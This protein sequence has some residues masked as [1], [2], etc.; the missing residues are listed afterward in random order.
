[1]HPPHTCDLLSL[2]DGNYHNQRPPAAEDDQ[3]QDNKDETEDPMEIAAEVE[4]TDYMSS[5][6]PSGMQGHSNDTTCGVPKFGN[7]TP[8]VRQQSSLPLGVTP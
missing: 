6:T 4:G 5:H 3:V 8:P 1:M 7:M 2:D